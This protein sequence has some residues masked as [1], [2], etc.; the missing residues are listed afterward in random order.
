MDLRHLRYFVAVAE[1]GSISGAARLCGISQPS[2]SEQIRVLE[3]ELGEELIRRLSRG[4]ALTSA[5]ELLFGHAQQI[6]AEE[7]KLKQ[8]FRKRA[9]LADGEV[10]FGIIPTL[11]PYLLPMIMRPFKESFSGIQV[12]L[13]EQQTDDL[14]GLIRGGVIE[15][16]LVSDIGA[17]DSSKYELRQL[18][19]EPLLLACPAGHQ[20][21]GL[22]RPLEL[23]DIEGEEVIQLTRGHC[24]RDQVV[25]LCDERVSSSRLRCDQ[26]STAVA[27]VAED[28]GVSFVPKLASRVL[29]RDGVVFKKFTDAKIGRQIYAV[30]ASKN[31]L[32]PAA[33][34]LLAHLHP[35]LA[36]K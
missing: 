2:M 8:A 32:S 25:D 3:S 11:A 13:F 10:Q 22:E 16:A 23:S 7:G 31:E 35:S 24:L 5:G 26:L 19:F 20:L 33:E 36:V 34:G 28:F 4:V 1:E 6:L 14:L 15:F 17:E 9:D 12:E 27:M 30:R 21:A 18:F 29:A